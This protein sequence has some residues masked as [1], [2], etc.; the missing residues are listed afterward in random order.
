MMNAE[1]YLEDIA[2]PPADARAKESAKK[3]VVLIFERLRDQKEVPNQR[4][5]VE[6]VWEALGLRA[7]ES[8]KRSS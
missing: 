2:I 4:E 5:E 7:Y 8:G 6:D 3:A 1:R